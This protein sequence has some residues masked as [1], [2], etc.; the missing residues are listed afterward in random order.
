MSVDLPAPFGPTRKVTGLEKASPRRTTSAIA[1]IVKGQERSA[2][3]GGTLTAVTCTR[4][5]WR[6]A[7]TARDDPEMGW[8]PAVPAGA[9]DAPPAGERSP[10]SSSSPGGSGYRSARLLVGS[11]TRV[12]IRPPAPIAGH[13]LRQ[14]RR[15]PRRRRSP[16]RV[17]SGPRA[18]QGVHPS[19]PA[20]RP[21]P[22]EAI[23][24]RLRSNV[25]PD[26]EQG[27]TASVRSPGDPQA[28]Y[29]PPPP[30]KVADRA[31]AGARNGFVL[32][33]SRAPSGARRRCR[34]GGRPRG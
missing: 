13:L 30:D 26:E 31:G 29:R 16:R 23:G 7:V 11:R 15:A 12:A 28:A 34:N 27:P 6:V 1:G 20:A 4:R 5:S 32:S 14:G 18:P 22:F 17:R 33:P 24:P 8:H 3:W 21:A 19:S 10:G 9:L 25:A 2:C